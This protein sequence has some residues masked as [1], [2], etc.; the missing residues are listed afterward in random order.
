[1]SGGQKQRVAIARALIRNPRVLILDE[2]TSAL[3]AESEHMVN[4]LY[5]RLMYFSIRYYMIND[6]ACV[7]LSLNVT[8]GSAGSEQRLAG[9][10]G[11]GDRPSAQHC[12]EGRQHHRDRQGLRSRAGLSQSADGQWW[13]LQQVSAEAGPRYRDRSGGLKPT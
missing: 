10:H 8:A 5:L 3:D 9:A 7:L 13:A 12:G 1:M 2:A 11:F 4:K 6:T